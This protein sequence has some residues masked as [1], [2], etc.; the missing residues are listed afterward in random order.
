MRDFSSEKSELDYDYPVKPHQTPFQVTKNIQ[1]LYRKTIQ[2]TAN[3]I[4]YEEIQKITHQMKKAQAIDIYTSAGNLYF[5]QNFKFQMQEIGKTVHVPEEEYLQRI[6]AASSDPGHLAIVISFGGR[7]AVMRAIVELLQRQKTPLV[8][9]SSTTKN[10]LTD[11][12]SYHLYLSSYE[13]H[14][15]KISSYGTR[16][17]LLYLL[18]CLYTCYFELDYEKNIQN[19][20]DYYHR[21]QEVG[22]MK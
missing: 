14:Y 10:A 18:D 3:L 17:S 20:L 4:D 2:A 7:G 21:L 19:K 22:E 1:E 15:H 5:A 6:S 11:A 16:L 12:A 9:I 13:H 8:L